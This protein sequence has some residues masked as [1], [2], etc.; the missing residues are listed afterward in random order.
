MTAGKLEGRVAELG[1][2]SDSAQSK[3]CLQFSPHFDSSGKKLY[4]YRT[5]SVC[6]RL[7]EYPM[8][9]CHSSLRSLAA[10]A[11]ALLVLRLDG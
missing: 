10:Q 2:A 3:T 4:C 1:D 9:V 7:G 6:I 8:T 5:T 11:D